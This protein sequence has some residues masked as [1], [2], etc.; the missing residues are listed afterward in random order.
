[1]AHHLL[2]LLSSGVFAKLLALLA[3]H[4]PT[5]S[6]VPRFMRSGHCRPLPMVLLFRRPYTQSPTNAS[7]VMDS[8]ASYLWRDGDFLWCMRV[9]RTS[10]PIL[11]S[12]CE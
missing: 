10:V 8:R 6:L 4:L 1:M 7:K 12:Q 5:L 3:G 11:E 9:A 2:G